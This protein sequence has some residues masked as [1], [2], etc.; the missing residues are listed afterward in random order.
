MEIST[1][2]LAVKNRMGSL[3]DASSLQPV[4]ARTLR[5]L[6]GFL[7]VPARL[8]QRSLGVVVSLDGL[9]VLVGGALA[10]AGDIENLAQLNMAPDFGPA[11]IP[12]AV[13]AITVGV[14]GSLIV[15]LYEK[16]FC[17]TIMR[18]GTVLVE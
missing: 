14:G 5:L 18:Q 4:R 10:L 1:R 6:V 2:R 16:H 7:Q 17:Y 3:S 11:R 9:A 12:I 8:I 15:V 13:Q